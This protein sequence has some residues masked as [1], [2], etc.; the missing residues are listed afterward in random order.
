[1][2]DEPQ[3]EE[4]AVTGDS[5]AGEAEEAQQVE[6]E[7]PFEG[8]FDPERA[9]RTIDKLRG[10]VKD[11][12][13][14]KETPVDDPEKG[15]LSMENLQLKVALETGLTAKQASRLRG[16][17]REEM[18]EDAHELFEAFAPRKE[19]PKTNRPAP[20]LKGGSRPE[21]EPEL[22]AK[23]IAAGIRL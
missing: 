8:E 18:L 9:R 2:A 4:E 11:L 16:E 23:D 19:E 21:V 3:V 5:V 14:Q 1:M 13:K 6:D 10:E 12:K 7:K 22:S 17:T 20:R 15:A